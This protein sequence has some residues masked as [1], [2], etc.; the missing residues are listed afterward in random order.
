LEV[1]WA[2]GAKEVFEVSEIDRFLTIEEGKG[3]K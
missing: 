2:G 1:N 3:K